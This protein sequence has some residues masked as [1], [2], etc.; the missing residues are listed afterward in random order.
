MAKAPTTAPAEPTP[1]RI[2]V[3]VPS[4]KLIGDKQVSFITFTGKAPDDGAKIEF[5][6]ES[7]QTYQATVKEAV[8]VRGQIVCELS[9]GPFP[10]T[11][12]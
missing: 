6:I 2:G 8:E 11:S 9:D 12:Q 1:V 3:A 4:R 5:A 7:G 10:V